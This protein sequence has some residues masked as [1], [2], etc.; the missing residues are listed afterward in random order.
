MKKE[1][2]EDDDVSRHW[3]EAAQSLFHN[4]GD[5]KGPVRAHRHLNPLGDLG[6]WVANT[7]YVDA[8]AYVAKEAVVTGTAHVGKQVF[9]NDGAIICD[10]A[11]ISGPIIL[12]KHAHF[13]GT[14]QARLSCRIKHPIYIGYAP[15]LTGKSIKFGPDGVYEEEAPPLP[16]LSCREHHPI[17][18][19]WFEKG[20][21]KTMV[22]LDDCVVFDSVRR[23]YTPIDEYNDNNQFLTSMHGMS[24]LSWKDHKHVGVVVAQ[25]VNN[26]GLPPDL[27]EHLDF[28]P[29][30]E[31]RLRRVGRM[32][33][34]VAHPRL[35]MKH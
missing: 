32:P 19:R 30:R 22:M 35:Y 16:P 8:T 29:V 25:S 2:S 23:G 1:F 9:M 6:G 21:I 3:R 11:Q 12:G 7:A 4:F 13:G 33:T 18:N 10:E 26:L 14:V 20:H 24:G 34:T 5:G 27:K 31:D 28:W 15:L 17:I